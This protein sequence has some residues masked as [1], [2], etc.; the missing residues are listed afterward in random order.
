[1][2]NPDV[3]FLP[4]PP[5]GTRSPSSLA[6]ETAAGHPVFDVRPIIENRDFHASVLA[7]AFWVDHQVS[8]GRPLA[9]VLAQGESQSSS[10]RWHDRDVL[11]V[12]SRAVASSFC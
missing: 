4:A 12:F 6:P 3:S 5:H 9:E 11:R 7:V 8:L 1:M 2:K 10:T